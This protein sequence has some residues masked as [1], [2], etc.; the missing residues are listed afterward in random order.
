MGYTTPNTFTAGTAITASDMNENFD[1]ISNWANGSIVNSDIST[2]AAIAVSKLAAS[3]EHLILT[4]PTVTDTTSTGIKSYIPFINDNGGN[5]TPTKVQW[6][7]TDPGSANAAFTIKYGL[8]TAGVWGGSN[9]TAAVTVSGSDGVATQGTN[10]SSPL[11][12]ALSVGTNNAFVLDITTGGTAS[13]GLWVSL[14]LSR[15]ISST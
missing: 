13:G 8:Y 3:K 5:W 14:F 4:F 15:T 11:G 1:A 6:L 10:T 7:C 12:S 9:V 2:S